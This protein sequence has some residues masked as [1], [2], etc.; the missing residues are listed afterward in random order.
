MVAV[1]CYP[2]NL[3]FLCLP[4]ASSLNI[5]LFYFLLTDQ[6]PG[7]PS[8]SEKLSKTTVMM[9]MI[10]IV[11]CS[12]YVL[13]F[14]PVLIQAV[15]LFPFFLS[16]LHLKTNACP[17]LNATHKIKNFLIIAIYMSFA[18]NRTRPAIAFGQR[19]SVTTSRPV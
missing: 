5:V 4:F 8:M 1:S 7:F 9:G 2:T 14:L 3:L 13:V 11:T 16:F 19:A 10:G 6:D 12:C 18:Y 15:H 17:L